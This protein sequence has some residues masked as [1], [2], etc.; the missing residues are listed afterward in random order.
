MEPKVPYVVFGSMQSYDERG[1]GN[2]PR[3]SDAEALMQARDCLLGETS[4]GDWV[5][6]TPQF[7]G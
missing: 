3:K 2:N 1:G 6:F 4:S 7:G 5:K